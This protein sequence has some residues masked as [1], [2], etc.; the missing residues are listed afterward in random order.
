[1]RV[2]RGRARKTVNTRGDLLL[3]STHGSVRRHRNC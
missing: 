3:G 1:L 2:Q